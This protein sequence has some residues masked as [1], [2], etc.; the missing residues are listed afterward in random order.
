[1]V[2]HKRSSGGG[3]VLKCAPLSPPSN[4]IKLPEIQYDTIVASIFVVVPIVVVVV[5]LSL[6]RI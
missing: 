5:G 3:I 2:V 4:S 1:M 6:S